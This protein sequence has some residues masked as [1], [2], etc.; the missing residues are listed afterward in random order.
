MIVA[1]G[2]SAFVLGLGVGV[3]AGSGEDAFGCLPMVV[4][5]V[6][7]FWLGVWISGSL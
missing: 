3:V 6:A 7:I 4:A 2:V 1:V 5:V